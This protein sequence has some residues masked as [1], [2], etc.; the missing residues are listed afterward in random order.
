MKSRHL[1]LLAAAATALLFAL[2]AGAVTIVFIAPLSGPAEAPPNASPGTGFASV[3]FDDVLS[4]VAVHV[5]FGGLVSPATAAHIHCCTATPFAG[6]VGVAVGFTGF[7]AA[8]GGT[9]DSVFPLAPAAFATLFSGTMAGKSY[10]NVHSAVF[11][12]GEIRGFLIPA[13]PVPEPGT[14]A[15]MLAGLAAVGWLSRKRR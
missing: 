3:A 13:P 7:P 1:S 14:Y 9:Y 8:T 11:P 4:T 12:G 10:V 6:V 5:D 2:P 15:L